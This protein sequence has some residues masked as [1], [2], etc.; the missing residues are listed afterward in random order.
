MLVTALPLQFERYTLTTRG[1]FAMLCRHG[2]SEP[3]YSS[4]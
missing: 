2:K 1:D 4:G 3:E